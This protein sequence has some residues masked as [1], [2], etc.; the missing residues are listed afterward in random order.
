MGE[1]TVDPAAPDTP[2]VKKKKLDILGFQVQVAEQKVKKVLLGATSFLVVFNALALPFAIPKL[3][4]FLGAPY[5]PMKRKAVEA[6]FEQVLPQWAAT[7]SGASG[8][9][10]ENLRLVDFGSGDGRIVQ[11]AAEKGMRA[12]GYE[13]NP[14]LV[15]WSR[16]RC[17]RSFRRAPGQ[18][19]VRWANAW[20]ADLKDVDVVTV[21]GR[22]GDSFMQLAAKKMDQE[23]PPHAAVVS[24]LF[25]VP[26]WER[27]LVQDVEG[28]RIGIW[29]KGRQ[30][31]WKTLKHPQPK[32]L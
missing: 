30:Q 9:G 17:W 19:E 16:L 1:A 18:G 14:Y 26:G 11:M 12:T 15:L 31:P 13:L 21:Y 28:H 2:Q 3:R 7:R 5:V 20:S 32:L 27:R 10:L 4:R 6:L 29:A 22:P 8:K 25:D 24:H 23:L